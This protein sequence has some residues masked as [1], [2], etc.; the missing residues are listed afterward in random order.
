MLMKGSNILILAAIVLV[1]SSICTG[2]QFWN[3]L[4]NACVDGSMLLLL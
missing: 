4:N 2:S 1:A 3:P